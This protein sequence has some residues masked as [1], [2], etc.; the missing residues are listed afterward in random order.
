MHTSSF[1]RFRDF[2][3]YQDLEINIIL[4]LILPFEAKGGA[5]TQVISAKKVN[6]HRSKSH[7]QNPSVHICNIEFQ[8]VIY[9]PS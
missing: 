8:E 7:I 5:T 1:F 6:T 2:Q 3:E 4:L 9:Y